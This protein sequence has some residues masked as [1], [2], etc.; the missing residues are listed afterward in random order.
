MATLRQIRHAITRTQ[1][2]VPLIWLRHRGLDAND[3]MLASYPRSGSTM[4]RFIM[5]EILTGQGSSF[6]NVNKVIPEMGIQ[7]PALPVLPGEGRLVKTHEP[8]R[9]EYKR[10]VYIV[11]DMR[12]VILSQYSREKELGIA[13]DD[14][15][16]YL[17]EF[18]KGRIAGYGSWH[19]HIE[20][21]FASPLARNGNMLVVKFDDLRRNTQETFTRILEFLGLDMDSEKIRN[22]IANNTLERM[23]EKENK[24]QTLHKTDR[25]DGRFVRKG[26]L[27]GWRER[28]T[29]AQLGLIDEYAGKSLALL[30]YPPGILPASE[31]KQ[32]L[33]P[34]S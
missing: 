34:Q 15:D 33:V 9:K 29:E 10:A 4:T 19:E 6:D 27:G 13:H 20:S 7:W 8:Y 17:K 22:A 24:A 14:F 3:V 16:A 11:R 25:E 5:V 1:I 23:R 21:W 31:K 12:D 2:R 28:L 26:S 30:G 18:L 32:E